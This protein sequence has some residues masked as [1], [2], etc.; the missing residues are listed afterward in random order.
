MR[1]IMPQEK[2]NKSPEF[3]PFDLRVYL[4]WYANI[5]WGKQGIKALPVVIN[6]F[7]DFECIMEIPVIG[8]AMPYTISQYERGVFFLRNENG[9]FICQ[10]WRQYQKRKENDPYYRA[11]MEQYIPWSDLDKREQYNARS[12]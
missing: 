4:A 2:Q 6:T 7:Q 10:L 5:G 12:N 9:E 3:N 11:I 1:A 8:K